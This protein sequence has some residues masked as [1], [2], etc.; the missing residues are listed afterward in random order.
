MYALKRPSPWRET[1]RGGDPQVAPHPPY[2]QHDEQRT[3][4]MGWN[5]RYPAY[6]VDRSQVTQTK[7]PPKRYISNLS[8]NLRQASLVVGG[9]LRSIL[10]IPKP[11]RVARPAAAATMGAQ[12]EI[13]RVRRISMNYATRA[14]LFVITAPAKNESCKN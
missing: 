9:N 5:T 3:H 14:S 1:P 7:Q 11:A 6:T 8:L 12:G 10:A 13:H 2:R 4:R